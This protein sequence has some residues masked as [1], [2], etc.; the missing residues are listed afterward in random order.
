MRFPI[1][2]QNF[3]TLR[4]DGYLY[5]D[6]TELIYKLVDTGC[7]YLLSRRDDSVNLFWFLLSRLISKGRRTVQRVGHGTFGERLDGTSRVSSRFERWEIR[8]YP[9]AFGYV[10]RGVDGLGERIWGGGKR[11]VTSVYVSRELCSV[12]TKRQ[13]TGSRYWWTSMTSRC[14]RTSATIRFKMS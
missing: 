10:E 9:V 11:S 13:G 5:I 8:K 7:Y 1:G 14:F 12:L 6:K 2:I 3:R 4:E